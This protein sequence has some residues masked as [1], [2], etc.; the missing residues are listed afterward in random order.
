MHIDAAAPLSDGWGWGCALALPYARRAN[1]RETE[2]TS[3]FATLIRGET[4]RSK[5]TDKAC[6]WRSIS[7]LAMHNGSG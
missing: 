1:D 7:N 3:P 5:D 2:N 6:A 4:R